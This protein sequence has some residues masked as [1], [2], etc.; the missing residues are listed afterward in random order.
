MFRAVVNRLTMG[1][2]SIIIT[3]LYFD[4]KI[5][6]VRMRV[7]IRS[8]NSRHIVIT[9]GC[10]NTV[11]SYSVATQT[12]SRSYTTLLNFFQLI[13]HVNQVLHILKRVIMKRLIDF[14][15]FSNKPCNENI[16]MKHKIE[17]YSVKG[18]MRKW[19]LKCINI[20]SST[21]ST[22]KSGFFK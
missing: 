3:F 4:F 15:I 6:D 13:I 5:L 14:L 20:R 2:K 9:Y 1:Y 7:F 8:F 12:F 22:N 18:M 10:T 19:P 16:K 17:A 21:I 11:Y